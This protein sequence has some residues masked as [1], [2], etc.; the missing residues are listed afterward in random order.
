MLP[1]CAMR[2]LSSTRHFACVK[3]LDMGQAGTSALG[4]E[5]AL[6]GGLLLLELLL[7][8]LEQPEARKRRRAF[9]GRREQGT[10]ASSEHHVPRLL[11]DVRHAESSAFGRG[12]ALPIRLLLLR[13]SLGCLKPPE[14]C[15]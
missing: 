6:Q 15:W 8:C 13:L 14:A 10:T 7:G 5:E 4:R 3:G 9:D 2:L 1:S 11:L 12:A